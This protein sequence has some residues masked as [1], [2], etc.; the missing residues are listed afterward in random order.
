MGVEN[1]ARAEFD[2][3]DSDAHLV[4][5]MPAPGAD[6][7]NPS[8]HLPPIQRNVNGA[9]LD[10]SPALPKSFS[11]SRMA[12]MRRPKRNEFGGSKM[13]KSGSGREPDRDDDI[14]ESATD[15]PGVS[16]V[17]D[18]GYDGAN[19][20]SQNYPAP[21][22]GAARHGS[23]E[24]VHPPVPIP[25]GSLKKRVARIERTIAEQTAWV[26]NKFDLDESD[27]LLESCSA[28]LVQ[29]IMLQGRLHIT[30]S[31]I[32]F[33]AKIFGRVTKERWPFSTIQ[34][35][36]K[37]RGGFVANSIKI[38]FNNPDTPPV[39][40]ASLNRREQ[41]LAIISARLSV[42]TPVPDLPYRGGSLE[43][44]S[45]EQSADDYNSRARSDRSNSSTPQLSVSDAQSRT[46]AD[47]S[48]AYRYV[49]GGSDTTSDDIPGGWDKAQKHEKH[50]PPDGASKSPLDGL[51]W[52]AGPGDVTDEIFGKEY[53]KRTEQASGVFDVPVIFAFNKLFV[54]DWTKTY[55]AE[56]NNMDVQISDWYRGEDNVLTRD[57]SFRRLLGYRLGPKETRVKEKHRY[58]FTSD[59]GVCVQVQGH[60]LDVPFGDYFVVESYFELK[61][62]NNGRSC[63]L[64]ASLAVHFMKSTMLRS[65]IETGALSETKTTYTK[66]V[67]LAGV[68]LSE[69]VSA[70]D[71]AAFLQ[72]NEAQKKK[73]GAKAVKPASNE[74]P[75]RTP[76]RKPQKEQK[77]VTAKSSVGDNNHAV[78][79]ET[80]PGIQLRKVEDAVGQVGSVLH[81][82]SNP[83][84]IQ[85]QD[86]TSSQLLR[87]IAIAGLIMVCIL[88]ILVLLSFRRMKHEF[89]V[90]QTI[91]REMQ[92]G[93]TARSAGNVCGT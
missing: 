77:N 66:L 7:R 25:E 90:L 56:I 21:D 46:S 13:R 75:V 2:Q 73:L 34:S 50:M 23:T 74:K 76:S 71:I 51:V 86:H 30:N 59:G 64:V 22:D 20:R 33:Y 87:V 61:P 63:E 53:A 40:I 91:V 52:A 16:F 65:K 36:R 67:E 68:H 92:A 37:R 42:F 45:E 17:Y 58:S 43:D 89:Q 27:T 41:T 47:G 12:F 78:C 54:S 28:A 62:T 80:R 83:T 1:S 24:V 85:M 10:Q 72:R 38:T 35:V 18:G 31:S 3:S 81:Q 19:S 4:P 8:P 29:K 14:H 79:E 39:I 84:I 69:S 6:Q 26:R 57:V 32:C 44:D 15:D 11:T 88:L 60:N 48:G 9:S 82:Q 5:P 70:E 49:Q 55:H 93:P